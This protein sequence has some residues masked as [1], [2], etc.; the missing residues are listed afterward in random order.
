M[1]HQVYRFFYFIF[2]LSCC[3]LCASD[4]YA[5]QD[6]KGRVLD[7]ISKK[8]LAY[9]SVQCG[10]VTTITNENGLFL[11]KKEDTSKWLRVKYLGY[12]EDS[13]LLPDNSDDLSIYLEQISTALKGVVVSAKEDNEPYQLFVDAIQSLAVD[14]K[15]TIDS[16][17]YF[18]SYTTVDEVHPAEL[19]EAY[20]NLK[21]T[22]IS[23]KDKQLKAGRFLLPRQSSFLNL[24]SLKLMELFQPFS[25]NNQFLFPYT[26][27][28]ITK[29]RQL[30]RY[31]SISIMDKIPTEKDTLIHFRFTARDS[32]NTFSG[33]LYYFAEQERVEKIILTANNATHIPFVS[34][35]DSVHNKFSKLS[36]SIEAGFDLF[37]NKNRLN[38]T[39]FNYQ[40]DT[41]KDEETKHIAT[42]MK[43]FLYDYGQSFQ[44]PMYRPISNST[45]YQ[46]ITYFP[47]NEYFFQRNPAIAE[48]DAE[49]K[50]RTI[51]AAIPCYDSRI[52]NDSIPFLPYKVQVCSAA[53]KPR[54][55]LVNDKAVT[56]PPQ[57][58]NFKAKLNKAE[59]ASGIPVS[60]VEAKEEF[61][62][63]FLSVMTFLDYDCYPDTT[64]FNAA[65]LFDYR[66]TYM[67]RADSLT[68]SFFNF[69]FWLIEKKTYNMMKYL[70]IDYGSR[71][72]SKQEMIDWYTYHS[73]INEYNDYYGYC[74][75]N[76]KTRKEWFE[77]HKMVIEQF[78]K[79]N[80]NMQDLPLKPK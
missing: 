69:M 30:K 58:K 63:S 27:F 26:P 65:L 74:K 49:K 56:H 72:P 19:F 40:F 16:K 64:V 14:S 66:Y 28:I 60:K 29:W 54:F 71:C 21:S 11:L 13:V 80:S 48:S 8:S 39:V 17:A 25:Y 78:V 24:S 23:I 44:L 57:P 50:V 53:A 68:I 5:Q 59:K 32:V 34:L 33:E 79:D 77:H 38:Y 73:I 31:Y 52:K 6:I 67:L 47:Y 70:T 46:L 20:Y 3:L 4:L 10:S 12:E 41:R 62:S 61:D 35:A 42:Y 51:F 36:Y 22:A 2:I 75:M 9:A 15:K 37:Q 7:K 55:E 18:K 43:L 76:S 1:I 45:D